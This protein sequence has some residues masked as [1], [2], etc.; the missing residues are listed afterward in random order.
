MMDGKHTRYLRRRTTIESSPLGLL[1]NEKAKTKWDRWMKLVIVMI[2][3]RRNIHLWKTT[4]RLNREEEQSGV[5]DAPT[6]A[7]TDVAPASNGIPID[8]NAPTPERDERPPMGPPVESVVQSSEDKIGSI[9]EV[10]G[11]M[12]HAGNANDNMDA[13]VPSTEFGVRNETDDEHA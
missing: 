7:P 1:R 8:G 13:P 2:R 12:A 6:D 5:N 11:G 4:F 10:H 3:V 9:S